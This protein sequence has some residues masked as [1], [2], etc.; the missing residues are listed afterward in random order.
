MRNYIIATIVLGAALFNTGI[1]AAPPSNL[2][3]KSS[4]EQH[5]A[6]PANADRSEAKL[7]CFY[8]PNLLVKQLQVV[9]EQGARLS[10]VY[11]PTGKAAPVCRA[12]Q[13]EGESPLA[14]AD[15]VFMGARRGYVFVQGEQGFA[16]YSGDRRIFFDQGSAPQSLA[17]IRQARDP[18]LR[19]WY[20]DPL[21]VRYRRDYVA[22]CSMRSDAAHCWSTIKQATGLTQAT[23][24]S[25]DAAYAAME[26]QVPA[27]QRQGVRDDASVLSY[28]VEVVFDAGGVIRSQ[29]VSAV[30]QCFP[31]P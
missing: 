9:D 11:I 23:A 16:V 18:E 12:Q 5:V 2:F 17:P 3:D 10:T 31:A 13:A 14:D 27:D 7:S 24:P 30:E 8:F 28:S 15:G 6:L 20:N 22:P 29:P 19:P 25:C 1:R 26:K 4:R 21:V